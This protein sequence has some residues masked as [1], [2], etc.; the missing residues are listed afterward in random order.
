MKKILTVITLFCSMAY[1][2][3]GEPYQIY[4]KEG[5]KV[6][7]EKMIKSLSKSDIV[8]FG[9]FHNNSLGHWLQLQVTQSLGAK[10]ELVLGAEMFE[11]DNQEGL[12]SYVR[13][14]INEEQFG[15]DV[16][17]WNN[18]KTD[19][20]PLVEYAKSNK[21]DF[22]A[23]NVPRRYA[24]LLF[25]KGTAA[26]DTLSIEE[27]AWIA[28]LPFPYDGNL[29]GYQSMMT[30]FEDHKDEN[31]PK[32]QAIKDAT[33]GHFIV[34]NFKSSK[35]FLHFNGS[36]HS[37]NFEGI[38]WYVNKYNPSL[39]VST[40]TMVESDNVANFEN[41]NLGLANF[42]IVIDANILKSF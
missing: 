8:L 23:T 27:K 28:P 14:E 30:M 15:K 18:Y 33:M 3:S 16:R 35:L 4:T 5:K 2:Q 19:Y 38:V 22:I 25:K 24:S 21:L 1:G 13:G 41:D 37:N 42:I 40:I 20:K 9:E 36:Y 34:Q 11:A 12:T 32:A 6:S 7:Y 10:K 31:L 39:K 17:L 29:P 26:L